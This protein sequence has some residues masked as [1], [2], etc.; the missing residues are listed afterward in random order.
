MKKT[1][2]SGG[3]VSSREYGRPCCGTGTAATAPL[4][5]KPCPSYSRASLFSTS[6]HTPP[7]GAPTRYWNR[8]TG[9]Q[10]HTTST[11]TAL[12][13]PCRRKHSTLL[14]ASL[15]STQAKPVG[16]QSPSASAGV[17]Q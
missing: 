13:C 14:V 10:L 3:R 2:A 16:S 12:E 1:T 15:Q 5:P 4:F 6:R 11:V 17:L 9:V 7:H 8:G